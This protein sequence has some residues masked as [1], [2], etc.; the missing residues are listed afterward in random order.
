MNM[1][2]IR[3]VLSLGLALGLGLSGNPIYAQQKTNSATVKG[4]KTRGQGE[5]DNNIKHGREANDPNANSEAPPD[6]GGPKIRG[7]SCRIHV[8]NRTP[9]YVDIYTDGDYRG[10]VSPWGDSYGWVGCGDTNLYGV[11]T[12]RGA[13]DMVWGPTV[14]SI[15]GTFT[16]SITR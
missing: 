3:Q 1:R 7:G 11:A 4:Q 13:P 12:F 14:Y 8:D 6:K 15:N 16:W 9:W 2:L 5:T 10:Q